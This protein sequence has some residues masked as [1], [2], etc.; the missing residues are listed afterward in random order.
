MHSYLKS[1]GFSNISGQDQI[2]QMIY[3]ALGEAKDCSGF[4]RSNGKTAVEYIKW[5][6]PSTGI[7]IRGEEDERGNFHYSHY[8]PFCNADS[9]VEE[10]N[11]YIDKRIETDAYSAACEDSRL[12][13]TLIFYVQNNIDYLDVFK[14][15]KCIDRVGVS[16]TGLATEGK[17]IL[18]NME[19]AVNP[20]S[21]KEEKSK[22][23]L[24]EEAKKGNPEAIQ[25]LTI[26]DIDLY[27]SVMRRIQKEDVLSIVKSSIIPTGSEADLYKVMGTIKSIKR[28]TNGETGE[29]IIIMEI[30]ANGIAMDICINGSELMGNPEV[31]MRF[32]GNV[33]LQGYLSEI[34]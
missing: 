22:K 15:E 6:S 1:I 3:K 30:D 18:P 10:E 23:V 17:I 24:L 32:R 26:K 21:V 33:W 7:K 20:I 5:T 8:F 34:K 13:I 27:A 31:G 28:E 11:V 9:I 4:C 16:Y 29:E 2:E 25:N 14:G 12:G 19:M